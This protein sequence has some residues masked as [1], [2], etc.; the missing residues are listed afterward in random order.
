MNALKAQCRFATYACLLCIIFSAAARADTTQN[1]LIFGDSLTCPNYSWANLIHKADLANFQI[2]AQ[3][4]LRMIDIDPPRH[5]MPYGGEWGAI[6]WLGTNDAG[7]GISPYHVSLFT[8]S[9]VAFL[10]SRGF[11]VYLVLPVYFPD[12]PQAHLMQTMRDTITEIA[13]EYGADIL[14][15]PFPYDDT[16]DGIHPSRHGHLLLAFYFINAL[17]LT[18]E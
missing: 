5:I 7:S 8:R 9:K 17:G 18:W 1:F 11:K 15:P 13:N 6:I 16:S 2:S 10:Q 4:G 14:D 12:H 3:P